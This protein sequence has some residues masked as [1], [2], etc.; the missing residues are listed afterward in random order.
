M[1]QS[2]ES[3]FLEE[4]AYA[5]FMTVETVALFLSLA[6]MTQVLCVGKVREKCFFPQLEI[7]LVL[8][9]AIYLVVTWSI[10]F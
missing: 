7:V 2:R 10:F 3:S 5:V 6:T 4:N 9:V 8:K 1:S